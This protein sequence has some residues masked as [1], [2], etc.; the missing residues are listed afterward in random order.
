MLHVNI[1]FVANDSPTAIQHFHFPIS[2][3]GENCAKWNMFRCGYELISR[4]YGVACRCGAFAD[5]ITASGQGAI[6]GYVGGKSYLCV[7]RSV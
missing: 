5:G 3:Y 1:K 4:L 2:R 6:R 7:S